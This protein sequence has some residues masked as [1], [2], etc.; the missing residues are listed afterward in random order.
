[1]ID[2]K[3]SEQSL[4]RTLSESEQLMAGSELRP[5]YDAPPKELRPDL[6]S[7]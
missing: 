5:D 1:M 6:S 3:H 4:N 2:E 7:N